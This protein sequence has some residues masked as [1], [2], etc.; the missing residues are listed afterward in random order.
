MYPGCR[1]SR[2][3][4]GP[5]GWHPRAAHEGRLPGHHHSRL[6]PHHREHHQQPALLRSERPG[7]GL[8]LR[9][10]VQKR[11][12]LRHRVQGDLSV[13]GAADYIG[14]H[15]HDVHVHPLQVRPRHQG[16]PGR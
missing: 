14:V 10:P 11:T 8:R 12:G 3:A 1:P 7:R 9:L 2:G 4:G 6:R 16:D 15:D 5:A 13:G